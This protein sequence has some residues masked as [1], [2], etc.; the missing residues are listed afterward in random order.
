MAVTVISNNYQRRASL[1]ANFN[2]QENEVHNTPKV[3]SYMDPTELAEA[4]LRGQGSP[5]FAIDFVDKIS[6]IRTYSLSS[7][8]KS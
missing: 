3:P 7:S 2:D 6:L 1:L 4:R 8:L 5:R